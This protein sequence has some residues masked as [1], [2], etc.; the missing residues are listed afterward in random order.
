[1]RAE[2]LEITAGKRGESAPLHLVH[3]ISR[4][5]FFFFFDSQTVVNYS[6]TCPRVSGWIVVNEGSRAPASF[7]GIYKTPGD[8]PHGLAS[9]PLMPAARRV[10]IDS[11]D[12]RRKEGARF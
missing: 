5:F 4:S 6:C 12:R 1:M 11:G 8:A 7:P 3:L 9:S 10:M 2:A